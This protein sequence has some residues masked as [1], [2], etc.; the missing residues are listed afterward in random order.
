M[1]RRLSGK[2]RWRRRRRRQKRE[3]QKHENERTNSGSGI[4]RAKER[5]RAEAANLGIPIY[6]PCSRGCDEGDTGWIDHPI[7]AFMENARK[8]IPFLTQL[9]A[10]AAP[11]V[12]QESTVQYSLKLSALKAGFVKA[13]PDF[14]F[15]TGGLHVS[16]CRLGRNR[17]RELHWE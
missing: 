14:S 1:S 7:T 12:F 10:C 6:V 9:L 13:G 16:L 4:G 3:R 5:A 15:T 11:S 2:K 17:E 8:Q